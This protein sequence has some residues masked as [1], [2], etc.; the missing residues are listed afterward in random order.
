MLL[1]DP[2]YRDA[3]ASALQ[4]GT[5]DSARALYAVNL[6]AAEEQA[7][8]NSDTNLSANQRTLELKRLELDQLRANTIATGQDLPPE[9]PGFATQPQP[10]ASPAPARRNYMVRPGDSIA[11]IAMVYGVPAGAIRQANPTVNFSRLRPASCSTSLPT[12]RERRCRF[13]SR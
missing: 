10:Q 4:A 3:L 5:P 6:A 1:Q 2:L 11:V 7:R 8:I 13:L 12:S 9:P